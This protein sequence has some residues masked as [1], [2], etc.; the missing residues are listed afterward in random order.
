MSRVFSSFIF[1]LNN[2]RFLRA[3]KE[4][5]IFPVSSSSW[6]ALLTNVSVFKITS[7]WAFNSAERSYSWV[8]S[9]WIMANIRKVSTT[10]TTDTISTRKGVFWMDFLKTKKYYW[11]IGYIIGWKTTQKCEKF[12]YSKGSMS[13]YFRILARK[14]QFFTQV[15]TEYFKEKFTRFL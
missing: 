3:N 15:W 8:N 9:F 13:R 1:W 12:V 10:E 7:D 4:A 14:W 6:S 5:V 11:N 2:I